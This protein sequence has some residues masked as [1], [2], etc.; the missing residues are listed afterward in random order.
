MSNVLTREFLYY[1]TISIKKGLDTE[2][3][4]AHLDIYIDKTKSRVCNLGPQLFAIAKNFK[5][6]ENTCDSC[7]KITSHINKD[8]K[9]HIVWRNNQKF[10]V[11]TNLWR[12]FAQEIMNKKDIVEKYGY[13]DVKKYNTRYSD[14]YGNNSS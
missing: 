13:V 7:F 4:K 6:N 10:R 11:F 14:D 9:M 5:E 12:S 1:C 8:G 2:T 3:E